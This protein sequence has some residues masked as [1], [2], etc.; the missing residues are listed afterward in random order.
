MPPTCANG[1]ICYIEMPATDIARSADFYGKVFGWKI[2]QRGD[3]STAFDDGV[4]EVSGTWVLRRPPSAQ[5]GLL[6][7]IMVDSVAAA[8]EAVVANGGE[9][10]QPLGADAPEITARFRDPGGNVV[11]L[12]QQPDDSSRRTNS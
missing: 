6:I 12:Y 10:V 3:G 7:Y 9:I 8:I 2:R 4:G 1:K 11:G 5:P